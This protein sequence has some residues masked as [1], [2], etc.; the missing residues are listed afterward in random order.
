M[1]LRQ[2]LTEIH[3]EGY[4][5]FT[6]WACEE[7][8]IRRKPEIRWYDNPL[9][10]GGQPS[11]AQYDMG[12]NVVTVCTGGRHPMDV[13]RSLAHELFHAFQNERGRIGDG[14]GRTGTPIE[15]DAN[16]MAGVLMRQWG[17]MN[18]HLYEINEA[19][20]GDSMVSAILKKWKAGRP[21]LRR[22]ISMTVTGKG[23]ADERQIT[24]DIQRMWREDLTDLF[25]RL[26]LDK[27]FEPQLVEAPFM[28]RRPKPPTR[29][30]PVRKRVPT[31]PTESIA[32]KINRQTKRVK[33][34][35]DTLRIAQNP[36]QKRVWTDRV[37]KSE[38]RLKAMKTKATKKSNPTG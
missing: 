31:P 16:A 17:R 7:L 2:I 8:G 26:R 12:A 25:K 27:G 33:I 19:T 4:Q 35:R 20:I 9:K 22:F 36:N 32:D 3:H 1:K 24:K 37:R 34:N 13:L 23:N 38:E 28:N 6:D 11:F 10:N 14:D 15:N 18:P 21:A 5:R 29:P 30:A